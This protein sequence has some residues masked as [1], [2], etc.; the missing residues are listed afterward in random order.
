M[1]DAE[2]YRSTVLVGMLREYQQQPR[3]GDAGVL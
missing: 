3:S 1:V 2:G